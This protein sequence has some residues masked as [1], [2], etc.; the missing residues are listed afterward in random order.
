MQ[1]A[2]KIQLAQYLRAMNAPAAI[3]RAIGDYGEGNSSTFPQEYGN[4]GT[5]FNAPTAAAL[6]SREIAA[7]GMSGPPVQS[8]ATYPFAISVTSGTNGAVSIIPSNPRRTLLLIQNQSAAQDLYVNL[9]GDAGLN[10]GLL[11]VAGQGVFFD[12]VCPYNAVSVYF[13]A[14]TNE[15]GVVI[16]GAPLMTS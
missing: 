10:N 2:T 16:E 3:R 13:G 4:D 14:A 7:P 8:F 5:A 9:S 6:Q 1:V 11:L 12:V 15:P